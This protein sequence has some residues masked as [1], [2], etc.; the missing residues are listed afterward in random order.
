M[1]CQETE[2]EETCSDLFYGVSPIMISTIDKDITRKE[3]CRTISLK[4]IN[5]KNKYEI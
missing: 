4:N 5:T 1:V 2:E 3:K